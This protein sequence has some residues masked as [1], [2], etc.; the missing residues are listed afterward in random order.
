MPCRSVKSR[1][2]CARH[3]SRRLP[4]YT[5]LQAASLNTV[6]ETKLREELSETK[7][8]LAEAT[9]KLAVLSGTDDTLK[10]LVKKNEDLSTQ[11]VELTKQSSKYQ[12]ESIAKDAQVPMHQAHRRGGELFCGSLSAGT[13]AATH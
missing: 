7:E 9:T 12:A 8:R 10:Q 4:P 3:S 11:V 2:A 13:R 5:Y 6:T 1:L